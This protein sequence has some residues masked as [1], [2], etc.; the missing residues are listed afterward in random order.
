MR[1][2]YSSEFFGCAGTLSLPFVDPKVMHESVPD[3]CPQLCLGYMAYGD[4][5]VD[6]ESKTV[7]SHDDMFLMAPILE[8]LKHNT[9]FLARAV[10]CYPVRWTCR[11]FSEELPAISFQAVFKVHRV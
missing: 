3:E 5:H 4:P 7:E 1:L 6:I 11:R 2:D 10:V 9:K 8:L